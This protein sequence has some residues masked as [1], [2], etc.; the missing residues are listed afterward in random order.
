[1]LRRT[2]LTSWQNYNGRILRDRINRTIIKEGNKSKNEQDYRIIGYVLNSV[3][4]CPRLLCLAETSHR[5]II[6]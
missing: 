4:V 3:F 2:Q 6:Q 1:M 5:I